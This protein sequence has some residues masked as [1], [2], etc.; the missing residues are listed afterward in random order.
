MS[1]IYFKENIYTRRKKSK[2]N[3]KRLLLLMAFLCIIAVM[4]VIYS[5][6]F[7]VKNIQVVGNKNISSG[8]VIKAASFFYNKNLLMI[9]KAEVQ[10]AISESV[11]VKEV[12]IGYRLPHTLVISIKER[13]ITAAIPYLGSFALIDNDGIVV[14]IVPKLDY[15]TIPVVTGF[16]VTHASVARQPVIRSNA[17]SFRKFLELIS[18]ASPIA[19]EISEIHVTVDESNDTVFY[20]YTLDG[21]KVFL[22]SYE[23][24]KI[25]IIKHILE[26]L[27]KNN[28]GKGELDVSG[29]TP[30]FKPFTQE[31]EGREVKP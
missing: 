7:A 25:S 11:P 4:P 9:K 20:L 5:P 26:D 29:D 15:L 14:K 10:K 19:S 2:I 1:G 8:E 23:E 3:I 30:V 28:R 27:R 21:F 13:E 12:R 31:G 17:D 22:G 24:K 18:T 6:L 16:D